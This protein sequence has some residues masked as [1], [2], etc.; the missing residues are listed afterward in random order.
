MDIFREEPEFTDI[1]VQRVVD[2]FES[3]PGFQR[4]VRLGLV[5]NMEYDDERDVTDDYG[6]ENWAHEHNHCQGFPML[7][8]WISER[9][10]HTRSSRSVYQ[11]PLC[12]Y[13]S[14][15]DIPRPSSVEVHARESDAERKA[16][17]LEE[18]KKG[19]EKAEKKRLKKQKRKERKRLEKLEKEKQN[20]ITTEEGKDVQDTKAGDSQPAND[21]SKNNT[22]SSVKQSAGAKDTDSSDSSEDDSSGEDSDAQKDSGECEEL[23]MTSTF[24]NKAALIA[25]RKLEQKPRPERREKKKIPVKEEAKTS[26]DKPNKD[27]EGEKKESVAPSSP[28]NV[29]NLKIS[30]DLAVIGNRFASAGDFNMAVKYFTDAIKYNPTEFKLFGNRSFCFEK[31]QEYEKALTDAELSLSMW[32]GWVKGLFRRGRALAGLKRYEEA[33]QAF[34]E[35]LKLDSSCA[36]AAQEL[37]RVQITQLMAYGFTREQSSNALIIHGTV[38][39]ALEVLSKLNPRPGAIQN[40]RL[41]PAQLANVTGVSPVLSANTVPAH[42][43]PSHDAPKT[44]FNSKP[45]GPVQ[46]MMNV[47]SQPKPV[48][49]PSAKTSYEDGRPP[50][51][52]FPVWVGNLIYPVTE[53]V[54]TNIFNKAG[55]VHSVKVLTYKRC[56]FVNFT[57]QEHCD[58]AIRRF[59]GLEVNGMKIAVRYPDR[60][61]PGMG[62]SRSALKADDLQDDY[63]RPNEYIDGR[64]AVGS[65][66]PFRPYRPVP[67]YRGNNNYYY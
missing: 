44:A 49:N 8:G 7:P 64:G 66:R 39:K 46:N 13:T 19:K 4:I 56:A 53:S 11:P 31:M 54:V 55:V 42:P 15:C 17:L 60:I 26:P 32:P 18:E 27:L 33:A 57:K 48:P 6:I 34:R 43:P 58:E 30:T 25:R 10:T 35:V 51:E 16:R 38:N 65:R 9:L 41:Q 50:Q 29:D 3:Q 2:L 28:T 24:V 21:E 1:R 67:D 14:T 5:A 45:L 59:H 47:P 12:Y 62:I 20:P 52:L 36:D 23:D 37:M 61:P 22:I 63:T 40:G